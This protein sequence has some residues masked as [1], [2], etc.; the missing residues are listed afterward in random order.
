MWPLLLKF[1]G[2]QDSGKILR[3]GYHMLPW[4]PHFRCHVYSPWALSAPPPPLPSCATLKKPRR[5]RVK[6]GV[7]KIWRNCRRN[8]SNYR[9]FLG[10]IVMLEH[11]KWHLRTSWFKIFLWGLPPDLTRKCA[12]ETHRFDKGHAKKLNESPALSVGPPKKPMEVPKTLEHKTLGKSLQ[13]VPSALNLK[14]QYL[15]ENFILI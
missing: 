10:E 4:Q 1:I 6:S 5:N 11:Q 7:P 3:Q 2:E 15:S 12:S 8:W 13:K 14:R 9:R